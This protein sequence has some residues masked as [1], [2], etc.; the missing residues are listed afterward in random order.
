[1]STF[2]S[3]FVLELPR[4]PF[5]MTSLYI[6]EPGD[7]R[8]EAEL[9][10]RTLGDFQIE[11]LL[12]K[13]SMAKVYEARQISLRRHVAL[14]VLEEGLF[15]PGENVKR[16]L[17]E[18]EALARLEHANI[19]PVYAAGEQS[20]YYFFAMRLIRG[21]T[22][23]E[24][25]RNGIK[26]ALAMDWA[27]DICKGLAFAH[28]S[29]VVHRDLKPTNVLIH[30]GVA[31]LSDFGLARLRDAST[32]TQMGHMLG[33]PLYM[34][35]EQTLGESAGPPADCFA[36]G[37][38]IYQMLTG[39]H[40]FLKEEQKGLSKAERRTRL[41][42]RIQRSEF[43]RPAQIDP[44]I[45]PSMENL[46]LK[47]LAR[48]PED[49]FADGPAMLHALEEA[50]AALMPGDERVIR[51]V[52]GSTDPGNTADRAS[53]GEK[54]AIHHH[55]STVSMPSADGV[56]PALKATE[57]PAGLTAAEKEKSRR[58]SAPRPGAPFSLGRYKILKELGHGGQGVVY[59]AHDPVLDRTI[60]LKVL[61]RDA[62]TDTRLSELFWHEARVAARLAHPHIITIYDFGIEEQSEYLTMQLI[63]GPSLDRLLEKRGKLPPIYALQIA[64]QAADA[65]GFAH[66]AGVIHL[67]VK[68][69]NILIQKTLRSSGLGSSRGSSVNVE[70]GFPH[71]LLTDFTMSRMRHALHKHRHKVEH[72]EPLSGTVPYCS[73]EQLTS[74]S[75]ALGPASDLFS[76]GAVLHEM[77]TGQPLFGAD[78]PSI[79]RERVLTGTIAAPSSV[80]AAVPPEVDELCNKLLQRD[81]GKRLQSASDFIDIAEPVLHKLGG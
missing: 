65:L 55:G 32:V 8:V 78:D 44:D 29:G 12:G 58:M 77:L 54:E 18:A 1:V 74:G 9:V 52:K 45:P 35:P 5:I 4:I 42:Q 19:V 10:G 73:P 25:M 48:R 37:I 68:P 26:R 71:V 7:S 61:R 20:P 31:L 79:A 11:T 17:R 81:A 30:D 72:L 40:P 51:A 43:R 69:G 75:D 66:Q 46:I 60:A 64:V 21:G 53:P 39:H 15:T 34:S 70:Y 13:G 36:L 47:A 38:I 76:L 67:D 2:A 63:D 3:R 23:D 41:F 57:V 27:G 28:S 24:A 33:T 59:E 80:C 49:R 16:F 22:L 50:Q 14:K 56:N 62:A 6:I